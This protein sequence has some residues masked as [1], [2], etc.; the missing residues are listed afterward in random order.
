MAARELKSVADAVGRRPELVMGFEDF[1]ATPP[2]AAMAFVTYCGADPI[3]SWEPWCWTDDRSPAVVHSLVSGALDDYLYRWADEIRDW[4]STVYLR[5]AHEFNGHWYPW[6]PA[7]GTSPTEYVQAWRRLHDVFSRQ[8]AGNV[9]WVWAPTVGCST[10]LQD[11]YPG[12]EYV[13]VLGVDGYNWGAASPSN[14]WIEPEDLFGP[15]FGTLRDISSAKPLLVTEVGCADDHGRKAEWISTFVNFL[16]SQHDVMGFV[17]F[18]HDKETDWR[19][20]ST[21]EAAAA[22]AGALNLM[23]AAS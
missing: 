1:F 20:T 15:T 18:E 13:D 22:M 2:V 6:S 7:C 11:W 9:Q 17:W 5:F 21:P 14:Q 8:G 19:M 10:A 23:R 3:V 12:D 4:G 16:S